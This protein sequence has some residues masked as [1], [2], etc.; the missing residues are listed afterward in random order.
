MFRKL[1]LFIA[2]LLCFSISLITLNGCA[3]KKTETEATETEETMEA[4][5]DTVEAAAEETAE[6]E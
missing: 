2:F 4:P 1:V 5:A 6:T 3:Q